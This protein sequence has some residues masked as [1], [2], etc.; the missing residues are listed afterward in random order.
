MLKSADKRIEG[1]V[2]DADGEPVANTQVQLVGTEQFPQVT[3]TD[4]RGHFTFT[5]VSDGRVSVYA[6]RTNVTEGGFHPRG[7]GASAQGGD[8]NVV[9][10][11]SRP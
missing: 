3:N 8:L 9:V 1:R 10:R 2:L 6:D 4:A 5:G 7:G 11:F